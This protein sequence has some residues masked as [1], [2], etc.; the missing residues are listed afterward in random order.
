MDP[1]LSAQD[2]LRCKLCE[3]P[4]PPM[5]CDTCQISLC[6][7]C[8]GEHLF[9]GSEQHNVV[10]FEKRGSI[11]TYPKCLKHSTNP[12]QLH[13]KECNFPI[14]VQCVASGEHFGH[15]QDDIL[16]FMK[17]TKKVIK[18]DLQELEKLIHPKYQEIALKIQKMKED[19]NKNSQTVIKAI[20]KHG[21]DW[22]KEINTIIE[23]LKHNFNEKSST[24]L[25]A[26]SIQED[27]IRCT[28]SAIT[29]CAFDMKKLLDSQDVS[30]VSEYSSR[31]AEFKRLP[32]EPTHTLP[33]FTSHEIN[34][35]HI[36]EQFGSLS[37]LDIKTDDDD[38]TKN[39]SSKTSFPKYRPYIAEPLIVADIHTE[40]GLRNLLLGVSCL[41]EEEVW[42]CGQDSILRLYNIKGELV[43]SV[44]IKSGALSL[45]I[46][47]LTRSNELVYADRTDETVNIVKNSKIRT[48]IRHKGWTPY[49]VCTASFMNYWLS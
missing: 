17:T 28:I 21:D 43:N 13:C 22:H 34:G 15:V 3:I 18:R 9:D 4:A 32:S 20:M 49:S 36:L 26:I 38:Y 30:L 37:V 33:S 10:Q 8:V 24:Q 41:S 11:P 19:M 40:Y 25:D 45:D 31:I 12:C 39:T 27:D 1:H 6:K 5:Y 16:E 29:Q 14:C 48:L 47:I 23:T 42:T 44:K 7:P 2:V 46:A 35:Q